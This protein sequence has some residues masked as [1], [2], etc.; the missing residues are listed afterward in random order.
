MSV[1]ITHLTEHLPHPQQE[2]VRKAYRQ[3]AQSETAAF[4][5]CFFLGVAGAHRFYLRQWRSALGHLALFFVLIAVIAAGIA[6]G[7]SPTLTA[8]VAVP[9]L[10]IS[11]VWVVIDLFRIDDEV[12]RRNLSLAKM[13]AGEALI[14][15]PARGRMA[16]DMLAAVEEREAAQH[17][18]VAA[19]VSVS[20]DDPEAAAQAVVA[21]PETVGFGTGVAV[22][23]EE[24]AVTP[25]AADPYRG[26]MASV[27][28]QTVTGIAGLAEGEGYRVIPSAEVDAGAASGTPPAGSEAVSESE[29]ADVGPGWNAETAAAVAALGAASSAALAWQHRAGEEISTEAHEGAAG[30][31]SSADDGTNAAEPLTMPAWGAA[32]GEAPLEAYDPTDS[33]ARDGR[34]VTDLGDDGVRFAPISDI[35]PES[36]WRLLAA[37]PSMPDAPAASGDTTL[38][39]VPE[40]SVPVWPAADVPS[41]PIAGAES[42]A[43]DDSADFA[44]V[45]ASDSLVGGEGEYREEVEPSPTE[46]APVPEPIATPQVEETPRHLLKHIRV[47]RQVKVGDDV[48]E[49]SVAEAYISPDEDP[50]PV[51]QRLREQLRREA[52]EKQAHD[53]RQ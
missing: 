13:L 23:F 53:I 26:D 35:E 43:S 30:L 19:A 41:W 52:E 36:A 21:T 7:W 38:L 15:D 47:V 25:A 29:V 50:E 24:E 49:E 8:A 45:P 44:P 32:R 2:A 5:W 40:S 20:P 33:E 39:L 22:P 14:H 18:P 17:V 27:A 37:S 1:D 10:L 9:L 46:P 28:V 6:L 12:S 48:V 4:L 42:S 31:N 34:D 16:L 51:R 11:L 3:R